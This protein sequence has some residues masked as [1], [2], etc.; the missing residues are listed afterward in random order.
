MQTLHRR[1]GHHG[2]GRP[3][4]GPDLHVGARDAVRAMVG[5]LGTHGVE[6]ADA[7]LLCSLAGNL[8]I[9]EVLDAPNWLVVCTFSMDVLS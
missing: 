1:D 6:P 9:G 5:V 8:R 7:D 4:A 3:A 2:Q